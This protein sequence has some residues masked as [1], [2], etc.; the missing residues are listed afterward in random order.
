[1]RTTSGL[2]S[3]AAEID[4]FA[5]ARRRARFNVT[6]LAA[7]PPRHRRVRRGLAWAAVGDRCPV[8][9]EGAGVSAAGVWVL[10][11]GEVRLPGGAVVV[12]QFSTVFVPSWRFV[13]AGPSWS[14]LAWPWG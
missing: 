8:A 3:E 5:Q 14:G 6:E 1:M 7:G 11:Q 9:F 2:R 10:D 12:E 13:M 4:P